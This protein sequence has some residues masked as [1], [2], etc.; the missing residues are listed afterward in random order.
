MKAGDLVVIKDGFSMLPVYEYDKLLS[1]NTKTIGFFKKGDVGI[2][3]RLIE[4]QYCY[5]MTH[6][7]LGV[8]YKSTI[9]V[10]NNSV[11]V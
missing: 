5:V 4:R 1:V 10:L 8:V 9:K 2:V 3:I 11:V 7:C 6:D